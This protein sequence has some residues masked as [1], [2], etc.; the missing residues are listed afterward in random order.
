MLYSEVL[1]IRIDIDDRRDR[2]DALSG[3]AD[4]H[5]HQDHHNDAISLYEE[6][7]KIFEQSGH[8]DAAADALKKAAD[9]RQRHKLVKVA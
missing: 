7:A 9:T 4:I 2:A 8:V 1:Q 5:R 3:L 6:A